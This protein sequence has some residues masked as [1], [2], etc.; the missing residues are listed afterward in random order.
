MYL[1][2]VTYETDTEVWMALT[3]YYNQSTNTRDI[4][5]NIPTW[6]KRKWYKDKHTIW[7]KMIQT[8]LMYTNICQWPTSKPP[9]GQSWDQC[10]WRHLV[11]IVLHICMGQRCIVLALV[12]VLTLRWDC[13]IGT[14]CLSLAGSPSNTPPCLSCSSLQHTSPFDWTTSN[15]VFLKCFYFRG[16][17]RIDQLIYVY[18]F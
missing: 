11:F 9:S 6:H 17:W 16:S 14:S 15:V 2:D 8:R 10:K 3:S 18:S 4:S 1:T 5:H 12:L 13:V 7:E